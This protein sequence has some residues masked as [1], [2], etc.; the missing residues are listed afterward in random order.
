[1]L[2][3]VLR[4]EHVTPRMVRVVLGGSELA[5]LH[6][7]EFT[8]AY[9]KLQFPAPG[10]GYEPPFD[11]EDV[12]ARR[13]REEW[14]RTRTYTLRAWDGASGE[15]MIDFVV[16]GDEGVA[17]P[18]AEA[19]K[20]GAL[21]QIRDRPGGAYSPDPEAKW[22]LMVGD[23]AVIPS[24]SASLARIPPGTPVH[25]ILAVDGP[26]EEQALTSTGDLHVSWHH[27]GGSAEAGEELLL[28]AVRDLEFPG[29]SV[30]A[31]IHGE[32]GA[33][34]AVRRHLLVDRGV[35]LAALSATGYWKR[36][37]TEE[38]WR[39]DKPEWKRLVAGD[40]ERRP[41]ASD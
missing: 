33:V 2:V 5:G 13:P 20:P 21:L 16:H 11:I 39:E 17:G 38:G 34:R 29:G 24:I 25:V 15:L 31:F 1:M 37:R 14:P 8:D 28:A 6:T 36:S 7:G 40:D 12:R 32:A 10:A 35:P 41:E 27:T 9:V 26:E 23:A 19:A 22:H 4:T 18:W 3:E 30:H